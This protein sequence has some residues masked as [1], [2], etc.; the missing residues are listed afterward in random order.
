MVQPSGQSLARVEIF[1]GLRESERNQLAKQLNWTR[2]GAGEQIINHLDRSTDVFVVITGTVRVVIY[3]LAG[4]EVTYRD[5][6][7]GS[8]FGELAAIDGLPRS[9]TIVAIDDSVIASMSAESF[10]HVLHRYP[11][12]TT[13]LVKNLAESVRSLTERVFEF[14]ALAVNNRIHAELLRLA[15]DHMTGDNQAII[16]P[17][18]THTEFASR[19]STRREAVARE[20]NDLARAGLVERRDGVLVVNDVDRLTRLVQDVVGY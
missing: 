11:S 13:C 1:Q 17:A 20:L 18:P 8:Y 2:Y 10:W 15:L 7:A 9:A 12:A 14:S 5:I 16:S 19:I 6:E 4:R 3:S